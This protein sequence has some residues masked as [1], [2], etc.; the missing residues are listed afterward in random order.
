MNYVDIS[1]G[2][3][4]RGM[5]IVDQMGVTQKEPNVEVCWAVDI[6]LWKETLYKTIR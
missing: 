1:L 6:P 2:E 3:Q 4:T 5:T